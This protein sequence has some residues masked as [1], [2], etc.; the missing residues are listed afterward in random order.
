MRWDYSGLSLMMWIGLLLYAVVL[1][2]L[3]VAILNNKNK[4]KSFNTAA[5]S[6]VF[7]HAILVTALGFSSSVASSGR[8]GFEVWA[9]GRQVE[10]A[11]GA[12]SARMALSKDGARFSD[13]R[14]LIINGDI[15]GVNV[16]ENMKSAGVKVDVANGGFGVPISKDFELKLT[17]GGSFSSLKPAVSY[18]N[19]SSPL[20]DIKAKSIVCPYGGSDEWNIFLARVNNESKTYSWQR[21]EFSDLGK[22]KA[23]ASDGGDLPDCVVLDY[24]AKRTKPEHRCAYLLK[25]DSERCPA[26]DKSEC[27][28]RELIN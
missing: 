6:L 22:I 4:R 7:I 3:F 8:L 21:I 12:N 19:D 18:P 2:S 1:I 11:G 20:L 24:D 13:E 5:I 10:V 28:Y 15:S 25:N 27:K 14:T 16:L 23:E 26:D 9:C 17:S